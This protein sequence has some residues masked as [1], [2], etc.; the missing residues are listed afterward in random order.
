MELTVHYAPQGS[1]DMQLVGQLYENSQGRVFFEYDS[2]WPARGL[3]LSPLFLP[4]S[5]SGAIVTPTPAF[6]PLFGLFEDALPDWWGERLMRSYFGDRGMRWN[7]VGSLQKL[8]CAGGRKMGALVF[9]PALQEDSP[10][11]PPSLDFEDL[12]EAAQAVVHGETGP[13]IERLVPSGLTPG[14]AQ[15]KALLSFSEDFSRIA[16]SEPPDDDHTAWLVKFELHPELHECKVE[17]AFSLMARAAGIE[18]PETRLLPSHQKGRSHFLSRRFDRAAGG[19]RIH[20]HTFSGLTHTQPR[21][22]T[23]YHDLMNLTRQITRHHPSVE[24]VFRRAVF[25]IAAGND[26][27]HGRNHAFLMHPDGS[28]HLA[29]AYDLTLATHPLT[30]G[31]RAGAVQGIMRGITRSDLQRLGDEHG[32]R[33]MDETIDQVLAAIAD[34]PHFAE[35]SGIP[36]RIIEDCRE[37]M[38]GLR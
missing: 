18:V 25:N 12:V 2:A 26:D 16:P 17:H 27:D 9:D 33:R 30:A 21:D 28:W 6:G 3:E 35:Q 14:G 11:H 15:P 37:R 36:P 4:S 23:D 32:V 22:G 34:W 7:E 24:Q 31:I 5:L 10:D 19:R 29:P 13:V 38:P 20:A 1:D 8:A